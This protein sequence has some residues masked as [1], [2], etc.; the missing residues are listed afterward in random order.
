MFY[1]HKRSQMGD[2]L[3]FI[4]DRN[5]CFPPHLHDSFEYVY[6]TS[7]VVRITV[8]GAAYTLK[9]GEALLIFPNQI[10]EYETQGESS[11]FLALFSPQLV[12]TYSKAYEGKVPSDA[13]FI[14]SSTLCT[15]A[16]ALLLRYRES[17]PLLEA[18]AFAYTVC[19]E[20]DR[21]KEYVKRQ[22][23]TL[24]LLERI[25]RFVENNFKENCSLH[26]LAEETS[27]HYVYLS[28]F[29][30]ESTGMAFTKYVIH[31]RIGE[32]SYRLRNGDESISQI[33]LFCGFDSIRTF[34]RNF[35]QIMGISPLE[36]RKSAKWTGSSSAD[37]SEPSGAT[38]LYP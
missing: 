30:K 20:F 36:Y 34:N 22:G 15:T 24:G 29:F 31:Y 3:T 13:L 9:A 33:A 23:D 32:A 12:R 6:V 37:L 11:H 2:R 18:K 35:K 16:E 26:L 14:P 21:E 10:H 4:T 1:E 28:R 17:T 5:L 27:Y 25:F 8:D 19:A 38:S 7:G